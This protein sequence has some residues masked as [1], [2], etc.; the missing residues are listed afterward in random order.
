MKT[1]ERRFEDCPK[2]FSS[3]HKPACRPPSTL[4]HQGRKDVRRLCGASSGRKDRGVIQLHKRQKHASQQTS[5]S[6]HFHS[7]WSAK[8]VRQAN[9]HLVLPNLCAFTSPRTV[10]PLSENHSS[11]ATEPAAAD[12]ATLLSLSE[13]HTSAATESAT[14]DRATLLYL[15]ENLSAAGWGLY[16]CS[17]SHSVKA[18][19]MVGAMS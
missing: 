9:Q 18:L 14:A 15:S 3:L 1:F 5:A 2:S 16:F 6:C 8:S 10:L 4:P 12:R 19:A 11:A 13:K 7:N 17:S